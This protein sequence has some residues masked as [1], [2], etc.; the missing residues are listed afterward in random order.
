MVE[1]DQSFSWMMVQGVVVSNDYADFRK[2]GGS[3]K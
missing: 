1:I 2:G 3:G